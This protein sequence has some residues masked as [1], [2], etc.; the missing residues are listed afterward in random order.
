M[1]F[2]VKNHDITPQAMKG[3]TLKIAFKILPSARCCDAAGD[4]QSKKGGS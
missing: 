4:E 3:F 2:A 1:I